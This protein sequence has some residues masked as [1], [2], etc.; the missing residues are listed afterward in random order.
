MY[1]SKII[2]RDE[3][4]KINFGKDNIYL[5]GDCGAYKNKFSYAKTFF[6]SNTFIC[7]GIGSGWANNVINLNT[8]EPIFFDNDGN[9]IN[10]EC[11]E[12]IGRLN[13]LIEF[14]LPIDDRAEGLWDLL[15]KETS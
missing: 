3:I 4:K 12:I 10:H 1:K 2:E 7:S 13:N 11:K 5:A 6:K 15:K 8:L 14:C 9:I